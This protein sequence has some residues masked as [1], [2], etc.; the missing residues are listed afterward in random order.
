MKT[1]DDTIEADLSTIMVSTI[2]LQMEDSITQM[3]QVQDQLVHFLPAF[4]LD[5]V[6]RH[7]A[8]IRTL[9]VQLEEQL[10]RQISFIAMNDLVIDEVPLAA[11]DVELEHVHVGVVEQ[12]S[13]LPQSMVFQLP[14]LQLVW[15]GCR[16]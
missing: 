4:A 3:E 13:D 10:C 5:D 8:R 6:S 7:P 2:H 1:L 12:L 16:R 9:S 15:R 11:L 14:L